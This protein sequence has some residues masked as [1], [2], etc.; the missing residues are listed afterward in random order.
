MFQKVDTASLLRIYI[1]YGLI[2]QA[3][4]LCIDYIDCIFNNQSLDQLNNPKSTLYGH[5]GQTLLLPYSSIDQLLHALE[6]NKQDKKMNELNK[7]L[8]DKLSS[9]FDIVKAI[10]VPKLKKPSLRTM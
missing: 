10:S 7:I 1:S 2:E 3:C 5:T 4:D 9:Y 6:E 8:Q